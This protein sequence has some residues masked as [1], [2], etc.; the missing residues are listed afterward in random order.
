M[1]DEEVVNTGVNEGSEGSPAAEGQEAVAKPPVEENSTAKGTENRIPHSRFNEVLQ[2]R[3]EERSR[4]E[5][6]EARLRDVESRLSAVPKGRGDEA[7][8][9]RLVKNLNMSEEAAR[10]LMEINR[11]AN[12]RANAPLRAQQ[13][14]NEIAQW[15]RDMGAKYKD[16][17]AV[18]PAMEKVFNGLSQHE[19]ML[20]MSG[21]RGLEMLYHDAKAMVSSDET[22]RAYDEGAAKAYDKK[23]EKKAVSN[24]PGSGSKG[25][26]QEISA[27]WVRNAS[28][29]EYKKNLTRVNHWLATG[30]QL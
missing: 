20:V 22:K 8:V 11:I 16:Y 17:E 29:E 23:A 13:Q 2:E 5:A 28:V 12:E 18:V 30:K 27:E 24:M 4:R 14:A 25:P 1:A 9:A 26:S 7:E 6:M 10:E 21:K 15:N 3:N 19:Q